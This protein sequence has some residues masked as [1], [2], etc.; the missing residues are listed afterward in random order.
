MRQAVTAEFGPQLMLVGLCS[1]GYHAIETALLDP[2]MSVCAVNPAISLY[3]WDP[4]PEGRF[5][6]NVD[7]APERNSTHPL[8]AHVV[9]RL[10]VLR[11][12][13]RKAPGGWWVLKRFFLSPSPAQIFERLTQS[14]VKLLVVAGATD[15][16]RLAKESSFGTGR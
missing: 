12:T 11:K 10:A 7:A 14:G 2:V 4:R 5:E 1:G 15:A 16:R 9:A 13:A 6:P 8:V 3:P